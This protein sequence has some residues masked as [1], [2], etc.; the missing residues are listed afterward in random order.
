MT[1]QVKNL[2]KKYHSRIFANVHRSMEDL[3]LILLDV[4]HQQEVLK[5]EQDQLKEKL[6]TPGVIQI[7]ETEIVTK[8]FS[9]LKMYLD[10]RDISV[11]VHIALDGVWEPNIT[12][13]WL[14]VVQLDDTI[15]DIGA[16][17]GYFGL[18]AA[19]KT[20]SKRSKVVLFE[21][22]SR[23]I[24]YVR[25][26]LAANWLIE[27]SIVENLAVSDK[28]GPAKLSV[29]KDY[30]GS[31]SLHSAKSLSAYLGHKMQI[32]TEEE[33]TVNAITLDDYCGQHKIKHINLIK[34]D[35]EGFEERAYQGMRNIIK[36]SPNLTLFIEFT[37][38]GYE[39]PEAFYNQM[40][41]DF[42][43]VYTIANGGRIIKP[44]NPRY[45]SVAANEEDWIMLIFSKN[46]KITYTQGES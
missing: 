1:N 46:K 21:A 37:K 44:T 45:K 10:P 13:A 32:E 41:A 40:L 29:L 24:P 14:S 12:K 19:Q 17:F 7:S 38:D 20:E 22:N 25:K 28:T 15:F 16:N 36:A 8:I 33:V 23:L 35:I 34:M 2:I 42:G 39:Q 31:S 11:A 5:G 3:K 26:S 18:L 27:Q 43:D 9:G 6:F 30:L 4:R